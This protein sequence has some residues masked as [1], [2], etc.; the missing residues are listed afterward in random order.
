M[1]DVFIL[2]HTITL[3]FN[4]LTFSDILLILKDYFLA[5]S[6]RKALGHTLMLVNILVLFYFYSEAS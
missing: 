5:Y 3:S 2:K 4:N 6:P 1:A